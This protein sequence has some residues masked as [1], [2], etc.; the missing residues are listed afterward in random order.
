MVSYL[1]F[2]FLVKSLP[3]IPTSLMRPIF[4][5]L[6][7]RFLR[8][9]IPRHSLAG[10]SL[11]LARLGHH[12]PEAEVVDDILDTLDVV[13]DAVDALPQGVV[14][15]VEDLEPGED[16]ADETCDADG[17]RRV[18]EGDGVG[19]EAGEFLCQVDEGEEV[20]FDRDVEA[21]LVLEID[22]DF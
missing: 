11:F 7:T 1:S 3:F 6:F 16:V 5:S 12:A 15:E 13:L 21:V 10:L 14:L 9:R 2:H 8:A 18:A 4:L 19:R 20:L 22:G 17:Q